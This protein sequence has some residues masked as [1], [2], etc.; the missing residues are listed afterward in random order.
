MGATKIVYCVRDFLSGVKIK[1]LLEKIPTV[2]IIGEFYNDEALINQLN[3]LKPDIVIYDLKSNK[4]TDFINIQKILSQNSM[5]KLI[6]AGSYEDSR[7]IAIA[8]SS[9]AKAYVLKKDMTEK[10]LLNAIKC[11]N[12]N[13]YYIS[14]CCENKFENISKKIQ[15]NMF[16]I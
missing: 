10:D 13:K 7:T 16:L 3:T 6:V 5:L 8:I 2:E 1:I 14:G 11:T 12:K 4:L 9:G 15:I